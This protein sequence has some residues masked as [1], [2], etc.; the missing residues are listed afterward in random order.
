MGILENLAGYKILKFL[1]TLLFTKVSTSSVTYKLQWMTSNVSVMDVL[2][3]P[4]LGV[5][6]DRQTR[7]PWEPAADR[8]WY[9]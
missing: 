9:A 2:A 4:I 1:C 7:T 5:M 3:L 6:L 8:L